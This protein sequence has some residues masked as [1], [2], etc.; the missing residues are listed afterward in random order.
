MVLALFRAGGPPREVSCL[1]SQPSLLSQCLTAFQHSPSQ[2]VCNKGI[3]TEDKGGTALS[4]PLQ[5]AHYEDTL[6]LSLNPVRA[7]FTHQEL[8]FLYIA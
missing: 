3:Q 4:H 2:A 6:L 5:V 8:L 1:M 7:S